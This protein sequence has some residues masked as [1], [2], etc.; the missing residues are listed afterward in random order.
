MKRWLRTGG[1]AV[2]VLL[3]ILIA[4]PLL[5]N[6]NRFRPTVQ[7]EASAALG[8]QVTVGDLSLSILS[9]SVGADNIAIADDPAFGKSPFVTAK[10]LKVGVELMP[11]IFS[12]KINVTDITLD[13]P[14][15][16]LLKTASGKW[17]FSSIGGTSAQKAPESAKSGESAAPSVSVAKLN[18]KSGRITVGKANASAK[19][20]VYD[21]V[22]ISVENF[23]FA[24]QFPFELVARLPGSGDA[25]IR[26]RAGP[27][28]AEDAAKT[29][30]ATAVKVNSMNIAAL[31]FIDPA[32]GIAG[33]ANFDGT[34]KSDGNRATAVGLFT[35][36]Q[37][38]FSPKGTPAPKTV[39]IKH[40]VDIDLEKQSGRIAQG[41]IV[42]GSAQAHLTGT[43]RT[44]GEAEVVNLKLDAPSMPVD[45]L[46]AM[47]PSLG[48]VLPSGSQLKGG[49]LSA[50]LGIMGPIDK[51][52]ITGP[53]RLSNTQLAN[54]DLGSKLGA[55]P[56]L[57]AGQFRIRILQSKM[58]ASMH[59]WAREAREP[60]T[61]IS[62]F[63]QSA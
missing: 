49:A 24:S 47:L 18:V 15:I 2:A 41:D 57:P 44:E 58:P 30:F 55:F 5:I 25:K 54:F 59:K 48:M 8:R 37:L 40:T 14:Q 46:E 45:E 13:S 56:P 33:L 43:F 53:V 42:I 3:L 4:L 62:Q 9:G 23:S 52:V 32:S 1:M 27:I 17:N 12:K 20:V 61:S 19:P 11:L 21:D 34:L 16:V 50:E 7:S 36:K 22:N 26:G 35:G 10:S 60:T 38:K 39:T 31:G 6:V 51:L 29:P 28:N 63:L